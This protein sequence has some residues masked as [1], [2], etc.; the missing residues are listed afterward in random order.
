MVEL[1]KKFKNTF[2]ESVINLLP[3]ILVVTG[4]YLFVF[5]TVPNDLFSI[6]FGFFILVIGAT[7]F[8][9]GLEIGIFPL[10]NNLS[11]EFLARKSLFWFALFGFSLGFGASIAEPAIISIASQAGTVTN[12][13]L[14]PLVLRILIAFSVGI[15]TAFGIIRTILGWSIANIIIFGYI[16]VLVIAFFTPAQIIGLAVDSGS[17][18]TNVATVP[19]IVAIG[20]G[21][22]SAIAGRSVLKDGFGFVALAV[23]APILTIMIYGIFA[24]GI[25][26]GLEVVMP[27]V[28]SV[29]DNAHY[30]E[31]LTLF[32]IVQDLFYTFLNL[33]PIILT[34]LFFQYV[35]IKKPLPNI[36]GVIFGL[37]FLVIGLYSF[38]VGIKLGLFPIGEAIASS[39]LSQNNQLYIYLFAFLI[40]F[41]TTMAEPALLATIKQADMMSERR[42][43]VTMFRILVAIGIGVGILIGTYRLVNGY[44]IWLLITGLYMFV[45][46]LAVF[47]PK[48]IVAFAFDLGG[49][50]ITVVTLPI[51]TAFGLFLANNIEG[52]DSL[53]DGFGLIAF[54][55]VFPMIMVMGYSIILS[56][57]QISGD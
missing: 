5:H 50:S 6:A 34:I 48:E 22:T 21:I 9:M 55:S 46:L 12:G 17:I 57:L 41:A 13:K 23:I 4:F 25:E 52:R 42:M 20:I 7:F 2:F 49:V 31:G 10:G 11:S 29:E 33:V 24:F 18:A 19:L 45:I 27:T 3:I 53:T 54:A 15:I 32:G 14:D 47:A 36:N 16:V 8:L 43:N 51:V 56:R 28:N 26:V 1:I 38:I 35:I 40:G 44:D 37:I 30:K 39:L